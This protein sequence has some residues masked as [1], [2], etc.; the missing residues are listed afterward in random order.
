MKGT[1]KGRFMY[2][3]SIRFLLTIIHR[4]RLF[5][6]RASCRS[7]KKKL[8]STHCGYD[9]SQ[10][11]RTCFKMLRYFSCCVRQSQRSDRYDLGDTIHV[12]VVLQAYRMR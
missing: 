12:V 4:M 10:S 2:T 5:A 11:F 9:I 6:T 7:Q 1:T 3:F 8:F